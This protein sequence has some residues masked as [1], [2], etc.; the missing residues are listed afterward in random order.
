VI[1]ALCAAPDP[2]AATRG[3]LARLDPSAGGPRSRA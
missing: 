1:S 2:E 3:L